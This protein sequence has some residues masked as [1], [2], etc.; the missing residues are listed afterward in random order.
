MNFDV[1]IQV[2]SGALFVGTLVGGYF[3]FKHM[4]RLLAHHNE[5]AGARA[6]NKVQ[7]IVY[8]L[9]AV[10]LTGAFAFLLH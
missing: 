6:L 2:V 5:N 10:A 8:W 1:V 9:H 7:L 4:D 3:L